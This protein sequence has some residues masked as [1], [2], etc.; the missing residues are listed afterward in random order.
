M[1]QLD[2]SQASWK[3]KD[4]LEAS[5]FQGEKGKASLE[6]KTLIQKLQDSYER[7]EID[8]DGIGLK[9]YQ[10][11]YFIYGDQKRAEYFTNQIMPY[12]N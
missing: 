1:P 3:G 12:I 5:G 2:F 7:K 4:F 9:I 11:A 10:F 6:F 8:L